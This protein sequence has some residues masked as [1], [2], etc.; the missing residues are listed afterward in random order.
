MGSKLALITG[1]SYGLGLEFARL[2]ARD[3]Y[4]LAI[5]ARSAEK[6]ETNAQA[7]RSEFHVAVTPVAADLSD[8]SS[9]E[10]LFRSVPACDV[11]IN[12]AGFANYGKFAELSEERLVEELQLDVVALTRMTRR[13]LPGMIARGDGKILNGVL[14][15]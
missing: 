11:L 14:R 3:G 8:P 1:A 5:A 4:D 7:L 9:I 13:Y 15:K 2:L 10:S 6:L 12:N